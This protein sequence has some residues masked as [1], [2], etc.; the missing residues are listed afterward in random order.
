MSVVMKVSVGVGIAVMVVSGSIVGGIIAKVI[1][2]GEH[3]K[4][5]M[6]TSPPPP[7]PPSSGRRLSEHEEIYGK[8]GSQFD[9]TREERNLFT[10][11]AVRQMAAGMKR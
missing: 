4:E 7:S 10:T 3:N 1:N 8:R 2:D 9:L 6:T 5:D 11:L